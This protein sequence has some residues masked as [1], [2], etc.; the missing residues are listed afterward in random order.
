MGSVVANTSFVALLRSFGKGSDRQRKWSV[1]TSQG[2]GGISPLK[3][4]KQLSAAV[5]MKPKPTR[6]RIGP[7]TR[8]KIALIEYAQAKRIWWNSLPN[9]F[10]SYPGCRKKASRSPHH[11]Y[12]RVGRL[13]CDIRGFR[14]VCR[15][16][17]RWIDKNQNDARALGL[18][19][20]YGHYN[21]WPRMNSAFTK[22]L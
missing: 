16:H 18:A 1:S 7:S 22:P 15:E 13:M 14:A 2:R 20:P 11:L 19:C 3:P 10:C 8:M 6:K 9:H 17:H 21:D 4:S 5:K 12:G